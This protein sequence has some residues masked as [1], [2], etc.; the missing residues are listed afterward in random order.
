VGKIVEAYYFEA[1]LKNSQ[2]KKNFTEILQDW[3]YICNFK[4]GYSS[5]ILGS[6]RDLSILRSLFDLKTI[7]TMEA[8]P[9]CRF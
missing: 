3:A 2:L 4:L 9:E 8:Q 7:K 1:D 6:W 5:V